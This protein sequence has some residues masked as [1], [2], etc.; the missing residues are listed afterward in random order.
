MGRMLKK[1]KILTILIVLS[2][3]SGCSQEYSYQDYSDDICKVVSG[4]Y[5]WKSSLRQVQQEYTISPGLVLSVIFHES[6]FKANAR[7]PAKKVIGF[8]PWQ[9][10]TAFGYAQIKNETWE[11]YKSHNPGYFQ[12]RTQFSDSTKFVG[13]YYQVFLARLKKEAYSKAVSDADFYISY[14]EGIGGFLHQN[15]QQKD[16]LVKKAKRVDQLAQHYNQQLKHC[17]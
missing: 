5:G 6:S 8:I 1:P 3:L 13:W 12:S 7:P 15:W 11:W 16:W 14:H 2:L 17:L 10:A 4:H 9:S